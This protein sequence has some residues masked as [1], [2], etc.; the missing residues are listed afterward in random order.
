[1]LVPILEGLLPQISTNTQAF[2][3]IAYGLLLLG[4]LALTWPHRS[5]LL[6]SKTWG[7]YGDEDRFEHLLQNPRA[8][9]LVVA[10]WSLC[11][12]CI[13]SGFCI[14][15]AVTLNLLLC[16]Y[17][18]IDLRWKSISRGFGAPGF[19][20]Y[21]LALAICLLEYTSVFAPSCQPLALLLLQVD[22][23]LIFMS[24]GIYKLTAGY[25]HN[26][27]MEY[28]MVNPQWSDY[29]KLF[30]RI[31]PSAF[32]FRFANHCAWSIQVIAAACMLYPPTRLLGAAMLFFSFAGIGIIIRLSLL[33][34]MIMLATFLY[35]PKGCFLDNV[36]A[37][38]P[39]TNFQ[40]ATFTARPLE[41]AVSWV[42]ILHLCMIIATHATIYFN[43]YAR[44]R[45][46]DKLQNFFDAYANKFG[47]ILWRV[48]SADLTNFFI[49]I[50]QPK[51]G[52][53]ILVNDFSAPGYNRYRY[54][55]E[56][57]VLTSLFTTR[58]YYPNNT[59]LIAEKLLR[60]ARTLPAEHGEVFEFDYI[61]VAKQSNTFVY[62]LDA[63]FKVNVKTGE[64]GE[65]TLGAIDTKAPHKHS[66]VHAAARPG[67]YAPAKA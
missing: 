24:S 42:L 34:P 32:V 20:T 29:C 38:I 58:K 48:F 30:I 7:G 22:F 5:R 47:I 12:L 57:I 31:P 52:E 54:V 41:Y 11:A 67:S 8:T 46:P 60:Y 33:C 49:N 3:R 64:V 59:E 63:R 66:P 62:N 61:S 19:L 2:V 28:G 10:L 56:S 51:N 65:E 14:L 15:P 27:G 43:F 50:Y 21:W 45:L 55:C 37:A 4:V 39:F 35:I 23:A 40:H 16:R 44:K 6:V 25:A 53:R 9:P 26:E 13:S 17:Y 36:I 18:F 1:M